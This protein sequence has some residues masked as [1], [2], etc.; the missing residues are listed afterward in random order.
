MSCP[1]FRAPSVIPLIPFS[2]IYSLTKRYLA[3]SGRHMVSCV[4]LYLMKA[5]ADRGPAKVVGEGSLEETLARAIVL[6]ICTASAS[7]DVRLACW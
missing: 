7:F 2:V 6:C 1:P 4:Q 3:L 5:D